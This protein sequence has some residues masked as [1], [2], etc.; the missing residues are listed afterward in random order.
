MK[1]VH[2]TLSMPAI[3]LAATVF[4]GGNEAAAQAS[5]PTSQAIST[6]DKV[7]TRIGPLDF[8]DG[9]PNAATAAKLYDNLDYTHAFD[10]FGSASFIRFRSIAPTTR[11][12]CW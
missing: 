2:S 5:A 11:R 12:C 8:K 3:V 10:A 1:H 4:T 6:P 9:A 7:E